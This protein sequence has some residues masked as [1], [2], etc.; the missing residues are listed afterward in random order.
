MAW[1]GVDPL[2]RMPSPSVGC[3]RLHTHRPGNLGMTPEPLAGLL[4]SVSG[5]HLAGVDV[6]RV[7]CAAD[8]EWRVTVEVS[9][10]QRGW[11]QDR[12]RYTETPPSRSCA[13]IV[14]RDRS[15]SHSI[16]R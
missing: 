1:P 14:E 11:R 16:L 4:G 2:R 6:S 7:G 9:G 3:V 8:G 10:Y 5:V 12:P 15:P 13:T